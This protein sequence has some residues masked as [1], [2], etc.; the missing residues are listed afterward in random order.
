MLFD[1]KMYQEILEKIE[2]KKEFVNVI[3]N[4]EF[5]LYLQPKI[6]IK[7]NKVADFETLIRWLHPQK[8]MIPPFKFI[9]I[10]E[11]SELIVPITEII[12]DEVNKILKILCKNNFKDVSIA[13]NISAK[14]F[15]QNILT[16]Q[17]ETKIK[18][19]LTNNTCVE[20]EVTE[21]AVMEDIN[22]AI[23]QLNYLHKL[24]IKVALDDYGTGHSS[25]KYLKEL[26]IDIIKIDKTFIDDITKKEKNY[27]IVKST[28]EMAKLLN[29]KTVAEGV[30]TKEQVEILKKLE[31]DY[32]QG[33]YYAKPMPFE[34]ALEF[35]KNFNS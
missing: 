32:I 4:K 13:I 25:L 34:E 28:I 14:H 2:I 30:E 29:M 5:V 16:K 23:N 9:P 7:E 35:L 12:L 19:N 8:G 3:E 20:I 1:E 31:V 22:I 6:D 27:T 11:N 33:Y 26:P 15:K 10:A 21:S 24:G 17:I 18:N